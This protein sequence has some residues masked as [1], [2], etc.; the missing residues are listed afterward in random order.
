MA[1]KIGGGLSANYSQVSHGSEETWFPELVPGEMTFA[2]Y[3]EVKAIGDGIAQVEE[4]HT[5]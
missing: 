4:S 2:G 1:K 5:Q 3:A